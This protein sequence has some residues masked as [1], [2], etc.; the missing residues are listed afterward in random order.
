MKAFDNCSKNKIRILHIS[1]SAGGVETYI[2][3]IINFTNNER[4]DHTVIC[5]LNGTLYKTSKDAGANVVIIP[6]I[7]EIS[8]TKDIIS[9]LRLFLYLRSNKPALIHAHSGKGGL[10]GRICGHYL[11]IPVIFT[12]HAFSYM[13][14]NGYKK[15]ITLFI[16]KLLRLTRSY[17]LPSAES[18]KFKAINEVGWRKSK[19]LDVFYN[20]LSI[21]EFKKKYNRNKIVKIVTLARLSYQKNPEMFVRVAIKIIDLVPDVKF[22]IIGAGYSDDCGDLIC[23]MITKHQLQNSI[24]IKP[25]I[26]KDEI[27]D[28]LENSDIYI[29]TSQ[30]EGLPTTLLLAMEKELP[31]VATSVDG[32]KDVVVHGK[33]G[34]LGANEDEIVD[35]ILKLIF[36]INL[37]KILGKSGRRLLIEKFNLTQNIKILETVYESYSRC[38]DL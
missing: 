10:F 2:I 23:E 21:S 11:N 5:C 28:I 18:E 7:R 16:E 3:N 33:T 17:L 15:R 34:F 32:N 20:S 6:M 9:L 1:Q 4:F 35:Y 22:Y 30:Y 25:W 37:R 29:S 8:P 26:S 19:V 13:S 14:Q 38:K 27:S 24:I 31:I 36:D 12:P